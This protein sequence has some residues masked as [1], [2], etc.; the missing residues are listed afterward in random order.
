M[1]ENGR[2]PGI[3]TETESIRKHGKILM[4]AGENDFS[5]MMEKWLVK[6]SLIPDEDN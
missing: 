6:I 5:M 2:T 1:E 4:E 3:R